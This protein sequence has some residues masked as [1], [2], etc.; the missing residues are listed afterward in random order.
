M[1]EFVKA[2]EAR[3]SFNKTMETKNLRKKQARNLRKKQ[4]PKIFEEG[5]QFNDRNCRISYPTTKKDDADFAKDV[6]GYVSHYLQKQLEWVGKKKTKTSKPISSAFVTK[7]QEK[8][9]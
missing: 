3:K 4:E 7:A 8:K 5:I 6:V 2:K 9:K 1:D